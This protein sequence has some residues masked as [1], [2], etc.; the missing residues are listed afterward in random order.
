MD[1][2]A[3][4]NGVKLHFIRP[5]KLIENAFIESFNGKFR[6]E[7]LDQHWFV[8]LADARAVIEAWRIDFNEARPHSDSGAADIVRLSG[9]EAVDF[10]IADFPDLGLRMM[11]AGK[12]AKVYPLAEGKDLFGK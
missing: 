10:G 4:R 3:Y 9:G 5:G 2:W 8:D 6:G 11:H 7:R 12:E 1:G